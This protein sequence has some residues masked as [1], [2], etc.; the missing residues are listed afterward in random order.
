MAEAEAHLAGAADDATKATAVAHLAG[1]ADDAT[2]A[3]AQVELDRVT[4]DLASL[5]G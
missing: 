2:K 5:K 4:A 3:I 1:A